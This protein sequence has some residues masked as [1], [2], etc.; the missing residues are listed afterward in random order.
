MVSIIVPIFNTE[1]YIP[2]CLD[3]I[4]QQDYEDFEIIIVDDGS[5][6]GSHEVCRKYAQKDG[7]IKLF[8]KENG[9]A[10]SARIYALDCVT[11]DTILFVDSDDYIPQGH[12]STLVNALENNMASIA[13]AGITYVPG[14]VV[15]HK[16]DTLDSLRFV[17]ALLYRDGVGDYPV[18][19][20]YKKELFEGFRYREGLP[21]EDFDALYD[22]F[23]KA[24]KA[25]ITD[26]TTYYY[27]Q[28]NGSA[29]ISKFSPSVLGRIDTC[30]QL[31]KEIRGIVPQLE[32]ALNACLV[33][34]AINLYTIIPESY[35]D[36]REWTKTIINRFGKSVLSDT[37]ATAKLKRK[38]KL[39]MIN[40]LL[41]SARTRAKMI[42]ISC[43]KKNG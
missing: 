26:K 10:A 38:I 28:R 30:K 12:I 18:S 6:D 29:S 11:G 43:S 20:L 42:Y 25:A 16:S 37:K 33:D 39:F 19:K 41:W 13:V 32:P 40:P 4:L 27:C 7:R 1:K 8:Q 3:S 36:E 17:E 23:S 5:K 2:A 21:G 34:E 35:H 31:E 15:Q 24:E 9:G 14:P 22:L